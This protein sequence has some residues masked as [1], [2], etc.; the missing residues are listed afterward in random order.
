[1][2]KSKM[3]L[4]K[5]MKRDGEKCSY[6]FVWKHRI[7]S[8]DTHIFFL[9]S[10]GIKKE[11]DRIA[12]LMRVPGGK[13]PKKVY[14]SFGGLYGES[15]THYLDETRLL[16]VG[17][18]KEGDCDMERLYDLCRQVGKESECSG[19]SSYMIHLV[20]GEGNNQK[21]IQEKIHHQVSGFILGHYRFDLLKSEVLKESPKKVDQIY[22]YYPK[23]SLKGI[24]E[25]FI[26]MS[27]VQNEVRALANLPQN[28]LNADSYIDYI[29]KA[30]PKGPKGVKVRVMRNAELK[31]RGMN[32]ILAVN[33]GSEVEAGLVILEYNGKNIEKDTSKSKSTE[34]PTVLVGKGVIYDTGGYDIK[35]RGMADM[36]YDMLGSAIM[37]GVIKSHA[38]LKSPGRYVA[39]LPIVENLVSSRAYLSGDVIESRCGLRVEVTD[40]DAEGR[41]ILADAICYACDQYKPKLIIDIGTLS[42]DAGYMFANKSALIM[43]NH[44]LMV[45]RIM[46]TGMSLH[47]KV[48][49][50]PMWAEYQDDL[51]S[52]VADIRSTG[53][54]GKAGAIIVGTFLSNFVKKGTNWIH[55]DIAGVD[56]AKGSPYLHNGAKG[57]ILQTLVLATS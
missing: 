40:T 56:Y 15:L 12:K 30:S 9:C 26:T 20:G 50:L 6:Q 21:G 55:L 17:Y 36:K 25:K 33:Q 52:D 7:S 44:H 31:K 42:G 39:L 2:K 41:L 10:H 45:Q 29:N 14:E 11:M 5:M 3:D 53:I 8:I 43:G 28:I 22:F 18:G 37:Y 48:W 38:L 35:T 57:E 4:L 16:F 49:E 24:V 32:L 54:S 1:M 34:G 47:E 27:R 51:R 19:K 13:F 23:A 46:D